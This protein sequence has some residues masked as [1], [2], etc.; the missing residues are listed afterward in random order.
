MIVLYF[1]LNAGNC[2]TVELS[3]RIADLFMVCFAIDSTAAAMSDVTF[4]SFVI[5]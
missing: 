4:R 3:K 2:S 1:D 5:S